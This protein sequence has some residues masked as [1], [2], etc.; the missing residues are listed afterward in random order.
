MSRYSRQAGASLYVRNISDRVRYEDLKRLFAKHGR[1]VDIT[2]PL[3]YYTHPRDAEDAM[4]YLDRY[5]LHN[6][7]L[8]IEFARGDRKTPS[9]MRTR[10]KEGG[11]PGGGRGGRGGGFGG[12]RGEYRRRSSRSRS[13]SRGGGRR[14]KSFSRDRSFSPRHESR[15]EKSRSRSRKSEI[16]GL[17][18]TDVAKQIQH[19]IAFIQQE[20]NEKVEE[21]EAKAE[22]EFNIEKSR[23][24]SQQRIKIME[25]YDKKEKQIELQRKIQHSNLLNQSRLS[26]LKA[27]DDYIQ[28]L[29]EEAR[30]QLALLAQDK[31]K[32]STILA[33]L[34]AQGLFILMES[35]VQVKCRKQD[36]ELVQSLIPDAVRRYKQ[37]FNNREIKCVIDDKNFLNHDLAGGVELYAQTGKIKVANTIE[38]RLNMIFQQILPEIRRKLFGINEH[39]KYYD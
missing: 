4:R 5:R 35:D 32:Y 29:K 36:F 26:V 19:M 13:R 14:E 16:M 6:R 20:A 1:I 39:R 18:E 21:I 3:D 17:S 10:E 9:E 34:I 7:E 24:V 28:T 30:K 8:E 27:R 2:V 37:E 25:Y 11:P 23:L 15:Q 33:N 38:A 22:E 12:G 31:Q